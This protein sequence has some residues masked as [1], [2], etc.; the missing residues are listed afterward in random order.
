MCQSDHLISKAHVDTMCAYLRVVELPQDIFQISTLRVLRPGYSVKL[1]LDRGLRYREMLKAVYLG[2]QLKISR[3]SEKGSLIN[4]YQ[5]LQ[6]PLFS[7]KGVL[8]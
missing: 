1:F 6:D 8:S 3:H 7:S 4:K 5:P 2:K